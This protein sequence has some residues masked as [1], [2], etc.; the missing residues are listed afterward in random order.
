MAASHD[1]AEHNPFP[2]HAS[3]PLRTAEESAA[4]GRALRQSH[5]RTSLGEYQQRSDTALALRLLGGQEEGR[6]QS[7]LPLRHERMLATP[8]TFYR[9]GAA[10]MAYDL[11]RS[12]Q[13]GLNVQLCG[14]AHMLNFGVFAA[15]DRDLVFDIN[16]FD[17]THPGPFE[18]DLHRLLASIVLAAEDRGMSRKDAKRAVA[19]A[20]RQY[21]ASMSAYARMHQSDLWYAR[22]TVAD[23]MRSVREQASPELEAALH[24]ALTESQHKSMWSAVE[25]F[26]EMTPLGRQFRTHPPVLERLEMNSEIRDNI[27][28][29]FHEYTQTLPEYRRSLLRKYEVIDIGHKVVGVGSVGLLAF[30]TLLRGRDA[31]DLLVL[32]SKQAVASVLEPYTSPSEFSSSGHRVVVGQQK[33]QAASDAFLGWYSGRDERH[34]YTR[35]LR[36]MKGSIDLDTVT[37]GVLGAYGALCSDML[38]RAHARTGDPVAISAYLGR[39]DV[40]VDAFTRHALAYAG[41]VH[42]DYQAFRTATT[43]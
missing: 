4:L 3:T 30:V 8:F 26:T 16:D 18:W 38:A 29:L 19:V 22:T 9:G 5:P 2:R 20:A 14:D 17:E 24:A 28:A 12:A 25:K 40:A 41:Q 27:D 21:E 7:L 43:G 15:P 33:M 39:G 6:V 37:P 36:D 13:S 35:Q 34:F 10:V 1:R 11:A 42:L 23:L 31:D 32:Q